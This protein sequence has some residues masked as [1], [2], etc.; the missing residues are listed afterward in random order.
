MPIIQVPVGPPYGNILVNTDNLYAVQSHAVAPA[1][2]SDLLIDSAGARSI[3]ALVPIRTIA[4][5]LGSNFVQLTASSGGSC[6]V[7][8]LRW[9]SVVPHPQIAG[10]THINYANHAIAVAGDIG[11][12]ERAF[13]GQGAA[14]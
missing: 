10:V 8:R 14:T 7:N 4:M 9:V 13:A 1:D 3:L 6:F 11:T 2:S 12:I 5:Q